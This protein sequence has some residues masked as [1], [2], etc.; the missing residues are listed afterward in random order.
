MEN[1]TGMENETTESVLEAVA[2][3]ASESNALLDRLRVI[4]DQPL[5][6]RAAA[7]AQVHDELQTRLEGGDSPGQHG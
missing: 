3:Q 5:Q 1:E 4:E 2:E 6:A 7:F